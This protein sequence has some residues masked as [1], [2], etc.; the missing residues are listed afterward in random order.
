LFSGTGLNYT[1]IAGGLIGLGLLCIIP[2]LL[3]CNPNREE[4][5]LDDDSS[6]LARL[7]CEAKTLRIQRFD[8]ADQI[9]FTEESLLEGGGQGLPEL[10]TRLDSLKKLVIPL[11]DQTKVLSDSIDGLQQKFYRQAYSSKMQ[12][13]RLDLAFQKWIELLCPD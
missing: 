2:F 7:Y 10:S 5:R 6:L 12:R 11:A 9:R 8:L 4:Q 13:K 1:P 3:S